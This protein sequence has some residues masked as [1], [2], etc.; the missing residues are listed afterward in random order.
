LYSAVA[1]EEVT[2]VVPAPVEFPQTESIPSTTGS[3]F[4]RTLATGQ[5]IILREALNLRWEPSAASYASVTLPAGTILTLESRVG[6]FWS[7]STGT[8]SGWLSESEIQLQILVPSQANSTNPQAPAT[9]VVNPFDTGVAPAP[10]SSEVP[11]SPELPQPDVSQPI[12]VYSAPVAEGTSDVDAQRTR[13]RSEVKV[14]LDYQK[15]AIDRA[16]AAALNLGVGSGFVMVNF[17]VTPDGSIQHVVVSSSSFADHRVGA[18]VAASLQQ[19]KL[20]SKNVAPLTVED[21]L[22]RVN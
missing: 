13:A 6:G 17:V 2:S 1:P 9:S 4:P 12:P 16:V 7:V 5:V 14:V 10:L 21:Y 3:S 20:Q 11:S 22:I 8:K 18:S 19:I 15:P